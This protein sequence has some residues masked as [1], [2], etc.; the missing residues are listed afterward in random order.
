MNGK[1]SKINSRK[2]NKQLH[3]WLGLISGLIIFIVSLSGTL[4]V[5]CDEIIDLIAGDAKYVAVPPPPTEKK[6]IVELMEVFNRK[7]PDRELFYFDTF[8]DP[9]R[10]FRVASEKNEGDFM[11]TYM[12][13]YTGDVLK[14]S[15]SYWFFFYI[16]S[17]I[18]AQLL[19]G[20]VGH[21]VV[22]IAT[23]IFFIELV[24]GLI[25]WFPR[26]W[27]RK[28]LK[29]LFLIKRKAP[30]KRVNYDLHKVIGFYI[31]I[32]ALIISFTGIIMAFSMLGNLTQKAFNGMPDGFTRMR[33]FFPPHQPERPVPSFDKVVANLF[34][35]YPSARQVRLTTPFEEKGTVY[36]TA[37]GEKVGLKSQDNGLFFFTDKYTGMPI[38]CP[39]VFTNHNTIVQTIYDLHV[40]HWW[41]L[42][43]KIIIFITGLVCT[44]LPVTGLVIWVQRRKKHS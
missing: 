3:L 34:D 11:Y 24:T 1:T 27:N 35:L 5:F 20:S 30:W 10:S 37:I 17:Q 9:A 14:N 41:G 15:R 39:Q 16:A 18:H 31:M 13:P 8:T 40:G 26:K 19:M 32:P 38:K 25:L 28:V 43:G 22:G 4:F 44:S 42:W 23:I 21:W 7:Y 12:D 36:Y 6:S 33:E 29:S 2:L